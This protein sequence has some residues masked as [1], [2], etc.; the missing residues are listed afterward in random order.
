M[1]KVCASRL[2]AVSI[3]CVG[4]GCRPKTG[5][6]YPSHYSHTG[7]EET[8]FQRQRSP[9]QIRAI[10]SKAGNDFEDDHF[11]ALCDQAVAYA[12]LA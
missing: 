12:L 4:T 9:E 6:L 5:L 10:F 8:D 7:V 3:T 1:A 2:F 11:K